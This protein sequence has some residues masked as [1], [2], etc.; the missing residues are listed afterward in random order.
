MVRLFRKTARLT[1]ENA[2]RRLG[3]ELGLSSSFFDSYDD[4]V[5]AG[6]TEA[7]RS[8]AGRL[9][10]RDVFRGS[11]RDISTSGRC[12]AVQVRDTVFSWDGSCASNAAQRIEGRESHLLFVLVP[13]YW[14]WTETW[15]EKL[16]S[17]IRDGGGEA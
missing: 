1:I 9:A 5:C 3:R 6:L 13:R 10:A 14:E 16:V 2:C 12:S 7:A 4:C 11:T 15:K 17:E 8:L